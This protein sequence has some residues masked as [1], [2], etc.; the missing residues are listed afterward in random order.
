M[1]KYIS[2]IYLILFSFTHSTDPETLTGSETSITGVSQT[3][4]NYIN[5]FINADKTI[6]LETR[7]IEFDEV[8]KEVQKKVRSIAFK[9]DQKLVYR[10]FADEKLKHG[11]IMDV[12][13]EMLSGYGES[14]QTQKYL[15]NTAEQNI[16]GSNWFDAIDLDAVK[17]LM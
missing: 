1:E 7:K 15:L 13:R 9:P 10:I 6:Y 12:N 11:F 14:V 17:K 16:D 2:L 4:V 8:E 3:E 5:V